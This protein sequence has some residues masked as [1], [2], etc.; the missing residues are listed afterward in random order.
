MPDVLSFA[1]AAGLG[2]EQLGGKGAG[3]AAMRGQGLRVPPGFIITTA[4][5]NEFRRTGAQPDSL[6]ADLADAL[7]ELENTRGRVLGDPKAPLLVA[8]RS[9]APV[10]MPGMM[11]TV[12]NVGVTDDT[13]ESLARQ[14]GADFAWDCYCRFLEGF[15]KVVL[16]IESGRFAGLGASH[17]RS[18]IDA[19]KAVIDQHAYLPADPREQLSMAIGAVLRSWD[20]PRAASYRRIEGIDDDMGTAVVV[21]AMVFGN[22]N[23]RS[24]TGVVFTRNPNTGEPVPYGDF[25]FQ[26]QGEDVV[27]GQHQTLPVS[28]LAD[29][30]PG[31]W[32]ELT[33]RLAELEAWKKDMLDVE[34]TVEDGTLFF[35]QVRTAKRSALGAVRTALSLA[36][37]GTIDRLEALM[38][39]TPS[40]LETLTRAQRRSAA[41][42]DRLVTGL[43]ACPGSATGSICLSAEA[44]FD[45]VDRGEPAILVR[46]ETSPDDVQGM[47]MAEGILTARG[48]LV[49]H[50]AV[51]ARG[52]SVP[53]VVGA[54]T[55]RIDIAAGLLDF[56]GTVLSEGDVITIDGD[57]GVV[58]R[59]HTR[60]ENADSSAEFDELL[61]WAEQIAPIPTNA[62]ASAPARLAAARSAIERS[63]LAAARG[64]AG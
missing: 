9:G 13:A 55:L 33:G 23:V 60:T 5:C 15:G 41:D 35:L 3:L 10:S 62:E 37:D 22:L 4:A 20:N 39:V 61:T 21:Q 52:L 30:L 8:V 49:S 54:D 36:R 57:T 11:D 59:G 14:F 26:A 34:F 43:A 17:G 47:A 12:L 28:V 2:A 38:R 6:V 58:V 19:L 63:G 44:V 7:T 32:R 56:G 27:S 40:Q 45:C 29:R 24:G 1:D 48:G 18:R 25:L 31:V 64:D 51:V 50:A 46:A 53:A 16:D 42:A